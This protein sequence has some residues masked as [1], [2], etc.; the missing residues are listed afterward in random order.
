MDLGKFNSLRLARLTSVGAFLEDSAGNDVLLPNR[1]VPKHATPGQTLEAFVYHDSE[2]RPVAVTTQPYIQL[3]E[4]AA[5]KVKDVGP[6]G[7]FMDWGLEKDLLVPFKEQKSKMQAGRRYIVYLYKDDVTGRLVGTAKLNRVVS[8]DL[9]ALQE[10]QAVSLLVGEKT[11]LGYEVIID[12]QYKGLLYNNDIFRDILFGEIITGYIKTLREDGKVDV[13]LRKTGMD[14]LDDG[15]ERILAE[16]RENDGYLDLHDK[17][18]PED[19]QHTLEMSK[20]Q[21]KRSLGMLYKKRVVE[22]RDDGIYLVQ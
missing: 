21:F 14:Y 19:I 17:S 4:F 12:N 16:L 9:S 8:N 18:D 11:D 5:L 3:H 15:A 22:I 7:A 13:T 2:D 6:M 20:K 1:Y 10:G